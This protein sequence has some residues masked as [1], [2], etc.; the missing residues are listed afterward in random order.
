[1]PN[2]LCERCDRNACRV[3][4]S[5]CTK[6]VCE[7]CRMSIKKQHVCLV[8]RRR[9]IVPYIQSKLYVNVSHSVWGPKVQQ[10]IDEMYALAGAPFGIQ[11]YSAIIT[12]YICRNYDFSAQFH[13]T[14]RYCRIGEH[15]TCIRHITATAHGNHENAQFEIPM[16]L[17]EEQKESIAAAAMHPDRLR[18]WLERGW[19]D[20]WDRYFE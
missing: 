16:K 13:V 6:S 10:I 14:D 15:Y 19:E 5:E 20:D 11:V 7:A 17:S 1:M 12:E 9:R 2:V 8:C 4:C 18:K 3:K